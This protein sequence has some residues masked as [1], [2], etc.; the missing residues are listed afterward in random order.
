M[1]DMTIKEYLDA[2]QNLKIDDFIIFYFT[3]YF[4]VTLVQR[5]LQ[6]EVDA[7]QFK[8]NPKILASLILIQSFKYLD[9]QISIQFLTTDPYIETVFVALV[10]VVLVYGAWFLFL[11]ELGLFRLLYAMLVYRRASNQKKQGAKQ[12]QYVDIDLSGIGTMSRALGES[13]AAY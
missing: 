13:L 7:G 5:A 2:I 4:F 9:E 6:F 11:S 12:R 10:F 1:F 8:T 3:A